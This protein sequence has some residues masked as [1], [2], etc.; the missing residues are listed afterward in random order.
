LAYLPEPDRNAMPSSTRSV[1]RARTIQVITRRVQR[2]TQYNDHTESGIYVF[3]S[4]VNMQGNV[5]GY[6]VMIFIRTG[7]STERQWNSHA[8]PAQQRR[9]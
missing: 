1:H 5:T 4:G 2:Q 7:A 9:L 3:D 8:D 6:G